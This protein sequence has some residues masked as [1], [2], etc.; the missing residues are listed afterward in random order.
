MTAP[1]LG[2]CALR[3]A[4]LYSRLLTVVAAVV[5][6]A[7]IVEPASALCFGGGVAGPCR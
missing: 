2:A 7:L 6:V 4:L 3:L 1:S 5:C